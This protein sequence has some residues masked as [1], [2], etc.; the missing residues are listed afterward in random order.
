[1]TRSLLTTKDTMRVLSTVEGITKKNKRLRDVFN[2]SST[3][4]GL[5]R[6]IAWKSLRWLGR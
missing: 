1:M 6:E 5:F 4:S 3:S 2:G